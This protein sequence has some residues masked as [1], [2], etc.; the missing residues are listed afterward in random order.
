M[1]IAAYRSIYI[2]RRQGNIRPAVSHQFQILRSRR[3]CQLAWPF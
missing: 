1:R 3:E 2:D